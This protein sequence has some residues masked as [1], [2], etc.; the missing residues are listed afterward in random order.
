[1][2]PRTLPIPSLEELLQIA[3]RHKS[4][5]GIARQI[6]CKPDSFVTRLR[7]DGISDEVKAALENGHRG[8]DGGIPEGANPQPDGS[9]I[10]VS[11][12]T[13]NTTETPE[14]LLERHG[15][16]I[17]D[18]VIARVKANCWDAMTSDKASGDNR[19]VTMRQLTVQ[20][21]PKEGLIQIPDPG[22]WAP[23]KPPKL[24]KA[25]ADKPLV[26]VVISDHH[27]PHQDPTFH[28]LFLEYLRDIQPDLIDINGDLLDF[29]TI[30]R[31]R[32]R[33]GYAQPVNDCLRAGFGILRDYRH[34]VPKATI[35]LKRGNHD[36]RLL[37]TIIDNN[38]EL[39][40]IAPAGE[41]VPALDLRRLL[42][43]DEL[44][45]EYI[46]EEWDQAK[47]R[48]SHKLTARHGFSTAK[49]AGEQMLDKLAGSTIQ[50]HTH[51]L[52]MTLR[53]EHT[54]DPEEP[55]RVRMALE[56]G[57][58]CVIPGGLGYVPG[59]EPNWQNACAAFR[60]WPDGDYLAAPGIYIPGR[61]LAPNGKRYAL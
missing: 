19:V 52:S 14:S 45:I 44:G 5:A 46:D 23:P 6:G 28:A 31:H 32:E 15:V 1:M 16:N 9:I 38:R 47:T 35:R 30:S 58:A 41:K 11:T 59:G 3:P 50:G 8:T 37:Y 51:R 61:F 57:C 24:R 13:P 55:I 49:N 22:D 26:G 29:S 36:E 2:A 10:L 12:P 20:V 4:L 48:L 27:A 34:T 39:H 17:D 7:I 56:G 21:V 53:T 33:E 43:L 18:W 60:I 25:T 42:H 54:G 40:R